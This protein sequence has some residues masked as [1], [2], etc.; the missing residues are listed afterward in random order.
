[1]PDLDLLFQP[2][3]TGPAGFAVQCYEAVVS[4]VTDDGV[5]VI[6]PAYDRNLEWGP[7]LPDRPHSQAKVGQRVA[8]L[9]SNSRRPWLIDAV[10]DA[11]EQ[12]V[13]AHQRIDQLIA[14][15]AA[16]EAP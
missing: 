8:V 6:I 15:V 14:R 1:M 3:A 4:R 5:R 10:A 9:M 2:A 12:F 13:Y 16:L 7:C 11:Y